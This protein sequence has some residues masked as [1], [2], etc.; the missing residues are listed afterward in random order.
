MQN[1]LVPI[2]DLYLSHEKAQNIKLE[3]AKL[4]SLDLTP[5]QICDLELLLNGG[6]APLNG[7]LS[8]LDYN[9][10]LENMRLANGHLWPIPI[11]LDVTVEFAKNIALGEDVALRDQEGVILAIINITDKW[12]PDKSNEAQKVFGADDLTH[13]G[14]NYLH[15]QAGQIYLGGPLI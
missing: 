1:N 6:F 7:F 13:P 12:T 15:N 5:R 2:Q 3:A 8:Q 9:N 11:N 4:P 14:V 10:V